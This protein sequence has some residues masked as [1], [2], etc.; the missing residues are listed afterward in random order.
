MINAI[1]RL[2]IQWQANV[3]CV[4][5][6][7]FLRDPTVLIGNIVSVTTVENLS[8]SLHRHLTVLK[9]VRCLDGWLL[10]A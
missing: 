8:L 10:T 3:K 6:Y 2:Q 9:R 1:I 5:D 7:V 4:T